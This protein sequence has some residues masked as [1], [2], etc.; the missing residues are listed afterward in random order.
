LTATQA[1]GAPRDDTVGEDELT[2]PEVNSGFGEPVAEEIERR[3]IPRGGM[4]DLAEK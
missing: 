2:G 3:A 4:N 1:D